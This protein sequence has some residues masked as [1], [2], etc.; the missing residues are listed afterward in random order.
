MDKEYISRVIKRQIAVLEEGS[1]SREK[2]AGNSYAIVE[3][4]KICI[5][6]KLIKKR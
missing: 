1:N 3:L 5:K 6:L 2:A 4:I